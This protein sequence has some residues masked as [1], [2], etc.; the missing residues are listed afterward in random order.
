VL[1]L[2]GIGTLALLAM[3]TDRARPTVGEA[4]KLGA[5]GFLPYL[6]ASLLLGAAF[7]LAASLLLGL[8]AATGV[9]ALVALLV[10]LLLVAA[11]YGGIKTSLIAPVVMVEGERNPVSAIK[12]SWALTKGNSVQIG[13]FYLLLG[14]AALV[15]LLIV[16]GIAGLIFRVIAGADLAATINVAMSS[17]IG[18]VMSVYFVAVMA[19]VHRQLAGPSPE[20]A[21]KPFE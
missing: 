17:V 20:A 18:A 10:V 6:A 13:L 3:L 2:E 12:R 8:A 1:V 19:A 5:S 7:G 16:G 21:S 9:K 15:L 4:I 14:I 11:I